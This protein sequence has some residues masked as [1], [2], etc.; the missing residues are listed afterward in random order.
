MYYIKMAWYWL[1]FSSTDPQRIALTVKGFLLGLLI[2][3]TVIAGLAHVAVPSELLTQLIDG[4]VTIV[5]NALMTIAAIASVVGI[6]RKIF[7][8]FAGT[9]KVVQ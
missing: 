8:T 3:L 2:N 9:N 5:Q 6:I 7:T 4:L 1:V